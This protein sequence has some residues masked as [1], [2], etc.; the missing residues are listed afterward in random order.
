MRARTRRHGQLGAST[1]QALALVGGAGLLGASYYQYQGRST[2]C[3]TIE[4][5]VPEWQCESFSPHPLPDPPRVAIA[6]PRACSALPDVPTDLIAGS[7]VL[8]RMASGT[9]CSG[10]LISCHRVLTARHCVTAG[11]S[12]QWVVF[13]DL[14]APESRGRSAVN[15][16]SI[17]G[18]DISVVTIDARGPPADARIAPVHPAATGS[19]NHGDRL[20]LVGRGTTDNGGEVGVLRCGKTTFSRYVHRYSLSTPVGILEYRSG[21]VFWRDRFGNLRDPSNSLGC[22]GDSGGGVWQYRPGEGWGVVGVISG[23]HCTGLGAETTVGD[24]RPERD[25][26]LG[27]TSDSNCP[28]RGAGVQTASANQGQ[29]I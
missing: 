27:D 2:T 1:V 26:I 15:V 11:G 14:D 9:Y 20:V 3:G 10:T 13:G 6:N 8:I 22:P 19:L 18:K 5:L 12:P 17:P 25:F 21:L 16:E 7:A 28:N 29:T 23:G 24:V 4:T